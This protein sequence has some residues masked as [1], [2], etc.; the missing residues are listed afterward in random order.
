MAEETLHAGADE[1]QRTLEVTEW[2]NDH[3]GPLVL[4]VTLA[5]AV[6]AIA[7][8]T[9]HWESLA[10]V[11]E[12][13]AS[14]IRNLALAAAIPPAA[15]LALWRA[16]VSQFQATT[17]RQ[18]HLSARYQDGVGLLDSKRTMIR[19][20]G[21]LALESLATESPRTH[22][23]QV[24]QL[25]CAFS[26]HP[27][28]EAIYIDEP[29]STIPTGA[30]TQANNTIDTDEAREDVLTA[31]KTAANCLDSRD[32][33]ELETG[34]RLELAG[35]VLNRATLS[36]VKLNRAELEQAYLIGT[37]LLQAELRD[38]NL[39]RS[40]LKGSMLIDS[41][42]NGAN[43]W[44]SDLERALLW[45]ADV[46][47]ANLRQANLKNAFI[48]GT[49]LREANLEG[50]DLRGIHSQEADFGGAN[51]TKAKLDGASL[52]G[53]DF[54]LTDLSAARFVGEFD[55]ESQ[56]EVISPELVEYEGTT[57]IVASGLTQAQLDCAVADPENP[58]VLDHV[59]DADSGA[60]L[61]WRGGPVPGQREA[62]ADSASSN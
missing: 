45:N 39:S 12:S 58:P 47:N 36:E 44:D 29:Q 10:N 43:L 52:D 53:A 46:D 22:S 20:G 56:F 57:Y 9:N 6:A 25:L 17:A 14:T 38:A 48:F 33:A 1:S 19:I 4:F 2:F 61:V 54:T 34:L 3:G 49:R 32:I 41:N 26:R 40:K 59:V 27:P 24:I 11:E 60:P 23:T 7:I 18:I 30:E 8:G 51:L 21:I 13:N 42:L 35:V 31:V 37:S 50:A 16:S 62:N 28:D 55:D 15:V 5:C